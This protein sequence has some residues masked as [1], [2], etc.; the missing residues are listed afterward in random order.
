MVEFSVVIPVYNSEKTVSKVVDRVECVL[1]GMTNEDYEI[2]LVNDGS[3]DNSE[4]VCKKLANRK[5]VKFLNFTKNFGQHHAL[6][7]GY[8]HSKGKFVI[9]VDDD[10]QIIPEEIPKL[11][12]FLINNEH[13]VVF[14]KFKNKKHGGF[15]NFGSNVNNLMAHWLLEKPSNVTVSSFYIMTR[16]VVDGIVQYKNPYP[17]IAGLIFKITDNI[18]NTETLHAEREDGKSNYTLGKLLKLWFNGFTNFSVKPLRIMTVLGSVFA[19]IGFALSLIL[20]LRQIFTGTVQSGWT[21]TIAMIVFF[22]GIQLISM[23]LLGE[24]VGRIF[25]SINNF[26][27]YVIK[28][29][30]DEIDTVNE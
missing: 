21:S 18:G 23:G 24:Y 27:Q 9:K 25:I 22:G 7:A 2:I 6:I 30:V 29:I 8:R 4:S 1:E 20:I 12:Q 11:Y 28:E 17:Y 10:L 16:Y 3:K 14:A 5:S 15:R 13:D 19:I 26:P